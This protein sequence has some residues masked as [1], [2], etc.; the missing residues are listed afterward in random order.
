M[1]LTA[2]SLSSSG[3]FGPA[4]AVDVLVKAALCDQ[5]SDNGD[6]D[7]ARDGMKRGEPVQEPTGEQRDDDSHPLRAVCRG[8]DPG[9]VPACECTGEYDRWALQILGG[10]A[11]WTDHGQ[12]VYFQSPVYPYF[13][14]LIYLLG[15]GRSIMAVAVVQAV[16]GSV[17]CGL[18]AVLARRLITPVAGWLAGAPAVVYAPG[19]FYGAFLLKESLA[20]FLLTSAVAHTVL[21]FGGGHSMG[22]SDGSGADGRHGRA[23]AGDSGKSDAGAAGTLP[24]SRRAFHLLASG[25]LWGAALAAWPLLIPLALVVMIWIAWKVAGPPAAGPHATAKP[26]ALADSS[27]SAV[28]AANPALRWVTVVGLLLAGSI[29]AVAPCTLRN[30]VGEGR[31]VLLSDAGP[32]NWQVGNAAN[33]TG[34]YIDFP[35]DPI[36]L[37]EAPLSGL[38]WRQY[39]RKL[40]LFTFARDIP[41]VTDFDLLRPASPVL[42]LPLPGFGFLFPFAAAGLLLAWQ[43][44][45]RQGIGSAWVPLYVVGLGY[46]LF[47]ALFFIVGRFRL[48]PAP[49]YIIFAALAAEE[50]RGLAT[51][52]AWSGRMP[53]RGLTAM[54]VVLMMA[55]AVN[56]PRPLPR[57]AYPFHHTWGRYHLERG[58]AALR[59]GRSEIAREAWRDVLKVPSARL[60]RQAEDRLQRLPDSGR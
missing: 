56:L 40:A 43:G 16:L 23:G 28:P 24:G 31:F 30:V 8:G 54:G 4:D 29:L 10:D 26:A 12:G 9:R 27:G 48:P 37:G 60:T 38:F 11:W 2:I 49:V 45:R 32:R 17:T 55:V 41:Q 6:F 44:V 39:G 14:A 52:A 7:D 22:D 3:C 51:R 34:T 15:G 25:V 50:M 58:D 57:G 20:T 59:A 19:I 5:E 33:S 36:T 21:I 18:T 13:V 46:P 53:L 1:S 47:M 42:R 35:K